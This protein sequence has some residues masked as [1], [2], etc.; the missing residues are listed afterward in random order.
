MRPV[1]QPTEIVPLVLSAYP[2]AIA[3][4]ERHALGELDVVDYQE[5]LA[6]ADIDDESLVRRPLA[7]I[8]QKAA[9]EARD[10]DPPPVFRLAVADTSPPSPVPS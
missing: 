1:H 6:I 10:F 7:I 5:R 8:W 4:T 2:Y 3:H 9:D